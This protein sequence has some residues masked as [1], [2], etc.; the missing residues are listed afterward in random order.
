MARKTLVSLPAASWFGYDDSGAGVDGPAIID[1]IQGRSCI[2]FDPSDN[3]VAFSQSFLMPDGYA[4][5]TLKADI[6][7]IAAANSGKVDFEMAV[8]AVTD[9]DTVDLDAGNS[10]DT[11]NA[12]N[13]TV[14]GTAGYL[15]MITITLTNKDSVAINDLVTLR[16]ERD[17]DDGTDDTCTGKAYVFAVEIWEDV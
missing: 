1:L 17:A 8:E 6:A 4:G 2:V 7:Y 9:A 3:W 15:D 11:I 16:L 12:V 5:G 14:P 13:A 10:F